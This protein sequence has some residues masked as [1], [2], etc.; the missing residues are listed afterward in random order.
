MGCQTQRFSLPI[1]TIDPTGLQSQIY[2]H[3]QIRLRC[4][5]ALAQFRQ[6]P[7]QMKSNRE[8]GDGDAASQADT[9]SS[10]EMQT[11]SQSHC[12]EDVESFIDLW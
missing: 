4:S 1:Y 2:S 5:S 8:L 10:A 9:L 3:L 12:T 7:W 11:H 6:H